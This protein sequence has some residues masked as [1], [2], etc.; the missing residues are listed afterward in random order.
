MGSIQ[1]CCSSEHHSKNAKR[2]KHQ[3]NMT[4]I[5]ILSK[6]KY[7]QSEIVNIRSP[8]PKMIES[9]S[10]SL[11]EDDKITMDR[12]DSFKTISKQSV[13]DIRQKVFEQYSEYAVSE[14]LSDDEDEEEEEEI[15]IYDKPSY[16][17]R[18]KTRTH[19]SSYDLN[20]MENDMKKQLNMLKTQSESF[21]NSN[22]PKPKN[23]NN[24]RS[25]F[26]CKSSYKWDYEDVEINKKEMQV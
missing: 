7:K 1:N 25:L 17:Y 20:N 4:K 10:N 3:E 19:W 18:Q 15:D 16:L 12:I 14:L 21:I 9:I 2:N 26:R 13:T 23:I 22:K 24:K 6:T 5:S 11:H 8:L